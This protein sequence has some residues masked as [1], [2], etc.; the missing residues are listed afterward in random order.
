MQKLLDHTIPKEHIAIPTKRRGMAFLIILSTL[1]VLCLW[2]P[3]S[4]AMPNPSG[5]NSPDPQFGPGR[6]IEIEEGPDGEFEQDGLQILL[7]EGMEQPD[8]RPED[9]S[10]QGEPLTDE[11]IQA[12]LDRLPVLET[13]QSDE[14]EFRL[15]EELLPPPRPGETIDE[16]FPPDEN[17]TASAPRP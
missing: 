11:E 4:Y 1:M 16:A 2:T 10:V 15:S 6:P 13:E 17:Q 9:Q 14:A 3:A 8:V 7:S 5:L 12:V